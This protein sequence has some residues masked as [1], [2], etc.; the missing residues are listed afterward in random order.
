MC[1]IEAYNKLNPIGNDYAISG[2]S[3]LLTD[4]STTE[5]LTSLGDILNFVDSWI[6]PF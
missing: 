3:I 5:A 2:G 4:V 6:Q 1:S